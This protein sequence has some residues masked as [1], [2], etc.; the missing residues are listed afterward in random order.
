M[1]CGKIG[2][3]SSASIQGME[4]VDEMSNHSLL[5]NY[6]NMKLVAV[7]PKSEMCIA[8]TV[9]TLIISELKVTIARSWRALGA[10]SF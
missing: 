4:Y 1:G 10:V 2:N 7:V 6:S 3:E 5:K 8:I 9:G